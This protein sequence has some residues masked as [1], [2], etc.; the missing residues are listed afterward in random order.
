MAKTMDK[1]LPDLR[2]EGVRVREEGLHPISPSLTAQMH[3][4]NLGYTRGLAPGSEN[5][6]RV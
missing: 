2:P 6:G 4:G 1:R 5:K 3:T